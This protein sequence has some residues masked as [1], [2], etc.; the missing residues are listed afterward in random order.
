MMDRDCDTLLDIG[1]KD[2]KFIYQFKNIRVVS[3]TSPFK[4]FKRHGYDKKEVKTAPMVLKV[5][6]KIS[7]LIKRF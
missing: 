3:A 2:K 5:K 4:L 1:F 6:E 7:G